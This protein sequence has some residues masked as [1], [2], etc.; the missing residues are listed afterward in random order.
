MSNCGRRGLLKEALTEERSQQ[1]VQVRVMVGPRVELHRIDQ[2]QPTAATPV[3]QFMLG[4]PAPAAIIGIRSA[5]QRA[6]SSA[7]AASDQDWVLGLSAA[8]NAFSVTPRLAAAAR[9]A[10]AASSSLKSGGDCC[11]GSTYHRTSA[12]RTEALSNA[13]S[14]AISSALMPVRVQRPRSAARPDSICV[15]WRFLAAG[16]SASWAKSEAAQHFVQNGWLPA[17]RRASSGIRTDTRGSARA[18]PPVGGAS[19]THSCVWKSRPGAGTPDEPADPSAAA[20]V[21]AHSS[22]WHSLA[23]LSSRSRR[24]RCARGTE[25]AMEAVSAA[26]SGTDVAPEPPTNTSARCVPRPISL[27]PSRWPSLLAGSEAWE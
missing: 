4:A 9:K 19:T 1:A 2:E 26:I 10:R 20:Q 21:K 13:K 24:S 12:K 25:A 23:A 18:S 16:L 11:P 8:R 17:V 22:A 15:R 5:L 6:T 27:S 7:S 14:P 3:H